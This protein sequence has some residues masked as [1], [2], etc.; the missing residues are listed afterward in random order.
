MKLMCSLYKIRFCALRRDRPSFETRD[1][2]IIAIILL[3]A[4]I[5]VRTAPHSGAE[6]DQKLLALLQM[7]AAPEWIPT[8]GAVGG[9]IPISP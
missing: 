1:C 2:M 3:L 5:A 8:A 4:V 7:A 9:N 6:V